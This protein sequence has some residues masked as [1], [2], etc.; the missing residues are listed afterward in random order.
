M[1]RLLHLFALNSCDLLKLVSNGQVR[2][3]MIIQH[4]SKI[5]MSGRCRYISALG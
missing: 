3:M 1:R 2:S 5:S 4:F